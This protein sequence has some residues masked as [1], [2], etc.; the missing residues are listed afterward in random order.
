MGEKTK[1]ELEDEQAQK[2][3]EAYIKENHPSAVASGQNLYANM[4]IG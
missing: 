4:P 2:E 1:E 3:A